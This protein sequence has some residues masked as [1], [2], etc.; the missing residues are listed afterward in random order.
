V[1]IARYRPGV[2]LAERITDRQLQRAQGSHLEKLRQ[3]RRGNR[4]LR[5]AVAFNAA[6]VLA[7]LVGQQGTFLR[8]WAVMGIFCLFYAYMLFRQWKYL[9]TFPDDEGEPFSA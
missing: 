2:G 7:G 1:H 9:A 3:A 5:W 8:F 6:A 4:L